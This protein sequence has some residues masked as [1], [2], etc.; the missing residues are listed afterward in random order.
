MPQLLYR[1]PGIDGLHEEYA[2][3]GRIDERA[4]VRAT[5]DVDIEA[6]IQRVWD[7]LANPPEWPSFASHIRDVH[8]DG[9]MKVDAR[10]TWV[11]G[12][13]RLESTFAVV[14]PDREITW[15]GVTSG[16][17]VVH[18][19]LLDATSDTTTH[20]RCEESMAGLLL[21]LFYNSAKLQADLER[22]LVALKA[23][24]EQR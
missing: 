15:T 13:R 23:A 17:K 7:L 5:Y 10:F 22:W 16:V 14:D 4:P 20:V 9:A 24:A 2:K 18:R 1:G 12:G 8:F 3:Q 21:V 11:T 6:P 19:H